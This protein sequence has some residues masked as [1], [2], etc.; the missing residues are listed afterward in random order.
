MSNKRIVDFLQNL[1][2]VALTV[3]ALYLLTRFPMMDGAVRGKMKEFLVGQDSAVQQTADITGAVSAVHLMVTDQYE[4]GRYACLN[5]PS[6]GAEF[7][8]LAPLFREAIGSAMAGETV[9]GE[10]L[11]AALER[12][13]IYMD[14]RT[15]L[16]ISVISAWLGENDTDLGDGKVR[17]LGLV[18]TEETAEL[19]LVADDGDVLRCASALTSN[20]IRE[21]TASFAPN[22]GRFAFE[23][24]YETLSPYS[25]LIQE[26]PEAAVLQADLPSE[27]TAYNLLTALEF[28]AHTMSRYYESSGV[29]VVMQSPVTLRI[30]TD[31]SVNSSTDGKAPQGI[32]RLACAGEIP[33]VRE[34]LQSAC[35]IVRVLREGTNAAEMTLDTVERTDDGWI[36]TFYY[37]VNGIRVYLGEDRDALRVVI[38]GDTVTRF[39]FVCR[40]YTPLEQNSELLPPDMAVAI[41]SMHRGAELTLAYVD[42]GAE[43]LDARWFAR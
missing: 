40:S 16:P 19:Y 14:L 10:D 12:P 24:G 23:S 31:G 34:A 6:A 2:L 39:D 26:S 5:A 18:A 32:Y 21:L 28:N 36:I 7:Q 11:R 9:S 43:T 8:R 29:E 37:H 42:N 22:D 1:I 25:I 3:S 33:T 15:A 35:A 17:A 4:Y 41:A 30:G 20:A 38:S 27:Y 13:G